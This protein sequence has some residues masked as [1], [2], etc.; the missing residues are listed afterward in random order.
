MVLYQ[1]GLVLIIFIKPWVWAL[2]IYLFLYIYFAIKDIKDWNEDKEKARLQ[3]LN[4]KTDTK[5]IRN[6]G[7]RK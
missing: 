7:K 5:R 4:N 2:I 6:K 1:K 3:T